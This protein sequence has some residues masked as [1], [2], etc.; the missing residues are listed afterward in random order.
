MPAYRH[1][2]QWQKPDAT[3]AS[4]YATV[5]RLMGTLRASSSSESI[6]YSAPT[7]I[8]NGVIEMHYRSE[9]KASWRA[10]DVNSGRVFQV[11]APVDMTDTRRQLTVFCSEVL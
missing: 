6:R 4:G 9:I 2:F 3:K 10:V 5:S 8:V 11:V 1:R 7:A